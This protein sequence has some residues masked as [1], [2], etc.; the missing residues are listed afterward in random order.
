ME[1]TGC[2]LFVCQRAGRSG[3]TVPL[4]EAKH[5]FLLTLRVPLPLITTRASE[6][7]VF[8]AKLN[9]FLS[10]R[11]VGVGVLVLVLVLVE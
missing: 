7:V 11:H 10:L 5:P 2:E 8:A 4:V 1:K 6:P 3:G 9:Y